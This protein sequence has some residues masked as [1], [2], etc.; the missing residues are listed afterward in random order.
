MFINSYQRKQILVNQ[1][2]H[3]QKMKKKRKNHIISD[4]FGIFEFLLF[5][6]DHKI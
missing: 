3:Y 5:I 1:I 2:F 4:S 6:S